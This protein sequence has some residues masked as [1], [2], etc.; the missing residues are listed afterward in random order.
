M[1]SFIFIRREQQNVIRRT[2]ESMVVQ[3]RGVWELTDPDERIE[4]SGEAYLDPAHNPRYTLERRLQDL[5]AA[6]QEDVEDALESL[7]R[8]PY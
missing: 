8:R 4:G 2:L 7:G 6:K 1:G 3:L 5:E